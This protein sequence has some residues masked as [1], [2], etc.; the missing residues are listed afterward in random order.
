M[1]SGFAKTIL[2]FLFQGTWEGSNACLGRML[3]GL[4]S[5]YLEIQYFFLL[6]LSLGGCTHARTQFNR[7][8]GALSRVEEKSRGLPRDAGQ[9]CTGA[10]RRV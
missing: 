2:N 7:K 9:E 5:R 8:P 10:T 6:L 1:R 4:G 3:H